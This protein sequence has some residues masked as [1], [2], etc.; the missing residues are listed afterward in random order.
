MPLDQKK[1]LL[2]GTPYSAE[3]LLCEN[4]AL[5]CSKVGATCGRLDFEVVVILLKH[6]DGSNAFQPVR[7]QSLI[8][9]THIGVVEKLG[10]LKKIARDCRILWDWDCQS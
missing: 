3:S 4:G 1:P 6:G 10:L 2:N 8:Q 7:L 9:A 5:N